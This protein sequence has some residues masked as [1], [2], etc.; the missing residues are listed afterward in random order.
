M[1]FCT[2]TSEDYPHAPTDLDLGILESTDII[3]DLHVCR[4]EKPLPMSLSWIETGALTAKCG[5]SLRTYNA[6]RSKIAR[7]GESH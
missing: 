2:E 4:N 5:P 6:K 1:W 3:V 7:G